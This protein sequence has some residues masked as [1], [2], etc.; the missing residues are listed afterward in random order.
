[1][2]T[3]AVTTRNMKESEMII[4]ANI[5]HKV[6]LLAIEIQQNIPNGSKKLSDFIEAMN[7]PINLIKINEIKEIVES[8]AENFP[9]PG[10]NPNIYKKHSNQF[11]TVV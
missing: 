11:T 7:Q 2:G 6:L 1:M 5:I 8:F 9:I 3:P 4:I 10:I